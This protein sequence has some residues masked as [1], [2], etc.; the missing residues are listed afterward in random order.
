MQI[1]DLDYLENV[2]EEELIFGSAGVMVTDDASAT[3]TSTETFA[4]G[5]TIAR[6]FTSGVSIAF[7]RGL[8]VANGDNPKAN[9]AVAGDG[10]LVLGKTQSNYSQDTAFARGFVV[11]IDLPRPQMHL[12]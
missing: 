5:T 8:A 12:C 6:S 4:L 7:G 9:V 11:A 2:L 1:T 3:G 10:D